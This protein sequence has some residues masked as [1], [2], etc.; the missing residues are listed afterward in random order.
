[1]LPNRLL[2]FDEVGPGLAYGDG[3]RGEFAEGVEGGAMGGD[4]DKGPV[5]V[6]PVDFD[7][8]AADLLQQR[9][10]NRLI[11]DEGAG[12]AIGELHAA[13]DHLLV[14]GNGVVAQVGAGRMVG[15]SCTMATTC[16]LSCP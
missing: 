9:R 10:R 15:E 16:P 4:I 6:L 2:D 8:L 13:K 11:I 7:D 1:M 3:R 5:V 14:V 12:A